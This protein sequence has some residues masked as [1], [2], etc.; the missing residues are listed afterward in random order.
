MCHP[1]SATYG[2]F[3]DAVDSYIGPHNCLWSHDFMKQTY[4]EVSCVDISMKVF[5]DMGQSV[6]V[7]WSGLGKIGWG[8]DHHQDYRRF[9][10]HMTFLRV[11]VRT[12]PKRATL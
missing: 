10:N 8:S 4:Q 12:S 1:Y 2:I 5:A 3:E 7:L 9:F 11:S 6:P